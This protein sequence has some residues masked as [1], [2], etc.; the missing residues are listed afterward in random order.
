MTTAPVPVQMWK[1]HITGKLFD[2]QEGAIKSTKNAKARKARETYKKKKAIELSKLVAYQSN[3]IRLNTTDIEGIPELIKLKAKEFWDIDINVSFDAIRFTTGTPSNNFFEAEGP[4]WVF[5]IKMSGESLGKSQLKALRDLGTRTD[6][7]SLPGR[8]SLAG[9]I[10]QDSWG[11]NP[12]AFSGIRLG[13]GSG[14]GFG[15][16]YLSRGATIY[17]RDFPL[18]QKKYDE[19]L[20]L[21]GPDVVYK[22]QLRQ[23]DDN[24]GIFAERT[25]SV[26]EQRDIVN[27]LGSQL[28]V[29]EGKLE[30]LH[31]DA[32]E[33]F[34]G[35]CLSKLVKPPVIPG[36]LINLFEC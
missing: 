26:S 23:I 33:Q 11:R 19:Y 25:R 18:L 36:D 4:R 31:M 3:F 30:T 14:A 28:K 24:A 8:L 35:F 21:R 27:K 7:C 16:G 12:A 9:T 22:Q 13:S 5:R 20:A 6:E 32:Q 29:E 34:K 15:D 1:C 2:T 10:L 17:L